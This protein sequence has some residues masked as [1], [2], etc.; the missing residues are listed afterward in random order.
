MII[1]NSP[2]PTIRLSRRAFMSPRGGVKSAGVS[3]SWIT[4]NH[5]LIHKSLVR[6]Q[7]DFLTQNIFLAWLEKPRTNPLFGGDTSAEN[8]LAEWNR[9]TIMPFSSSAFHSKKY[10]AKRHILRAYDCY[11]SWCPTPLLIVAQYYNTFGLLLTH[12]VRE[13]GDRHKVGIEQISFCNK[14]LTFILRPFK[15]TDTVKRILEAQ[16]TAK[17]ER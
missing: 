10:R 1:A 13:I 11:E 6:N 14:D 16:R 4:N 5:W 7:L 3:P 9:S 8:L 17:G 15:S 2:T 12:Y